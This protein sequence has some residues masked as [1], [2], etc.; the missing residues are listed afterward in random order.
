MKYS[1]Y[2]NKKKPPVGEV[3]DEEV[4]NIIRHDEKLAHMTLDI[5]QHLTANDIA[6]ADFIKG[7]LPSVTF[8]ARF[9]GGRRYDKLIEYNG[10][11]PIDLDKKT[12]EELARISAAVTRSPFTHISFTSPKGNG[13]KLTVQ[14]SL[15]DGTLPQSPEEVRNY[16]AHAY[17]QVAALY[18]EL[19]QTDIDESGKDMT[20]ICYLPH[21]ENAYLNPAP[22]FLIVDLNRP[23][24]EKKKKTPGRKKAAAATTDTTRCKKP[25]DN[26][27]YP[28]SE[29]RSLLA[30]LLYYHDHKNKYEE[31]NRNN[32]LFRLTCTYNAYGIPKEEVA[33]FLRLNF[34][35]MPPE[36]IDSLT[37]SA[38]QHTDE[39]NTRKLRTSQWN[40]LRIG[41]YI[42]SH[43]ETRYNQM[44]HR[45]ECRKKGEDDFVML[46]DMVSNSI[47]MELNEAGYPCSVKNMEN[48]IY[49]DFSFSYHPIREYMNH[50][51]PWDG[52]DHIG[53]LAESVHTIPAQREFWL[54]G[55][56]N[57]LVGMVAAATQEEVVNHLCLLLCSK[58]N[59]GKTTFINNILPR[60]LRT[61]Y[62]STGIIS[63][64]N[65]DD[66]SR[67]SEY[68]LINFD[69]FE[70]MTGH[71]LSLLKDLITRKFISIR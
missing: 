15:P 71:E 50:L 12:P 16:H 2:Q 43:Y 40:F 67:M 26:I 13:Y 44:K 8:S 59:L 41:Q 35:D 17:D 28:Q 21:D 23:L 58:Q 61:D 51:P 24:R 31:G 32:Y 10:E 49:S 18:E 19:C 6:T 22:Q 20:R 5:R 30:L 63:A 68:M 14:T 60:E 39:F 54:K 66:L 65:K 53:C 11:I 55:F 64:G 27:S 42:N 56:R 57:F 1:Y 69:E 46:D 4:V 9:I 70:G 25:S 37:D 38:Y 34:T 52:I 47:W 62:L 48:L 36:E 7:E 29:S 3:T 33:P 45:M